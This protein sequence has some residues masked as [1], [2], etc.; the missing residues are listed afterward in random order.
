MS[1]FESIYLKLLRTQVDEEIAFLMRNGH[2]NEQIRVPCMFCTQRPQGHY[3]CYRLNELRR[4]QSSIVQ[5]EFN[6]NRHQEKNIPKSR[7]AIGFDER[8]IHQ[9][10]KQSINIIPE[11]DFSR[12]PLLS[13]EL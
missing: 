7:R 13:T 4:F 8:P 6:N 2:D 11:V 3:V 9:G 12:M 10:N 1:D 5:H